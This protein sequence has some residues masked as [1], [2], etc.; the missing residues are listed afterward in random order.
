M[1]IDPAD[2]V[3]NSNSASILSRVRSVNGRNAPNASAFHTQSHL[4]AASMGKSA[5]RVVMPQ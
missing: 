4:S 3:M 2:S 1:M 5:K